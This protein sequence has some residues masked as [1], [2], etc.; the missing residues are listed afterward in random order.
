MR[1]FNLSPF[2]YIRRLSDKNEIE[3][4][5]KDPNYIVTVLGGL[6]LN[7]RDYEYK[8]SQV[9]L[10]DKRNEHKHLQF[11]YANNPV[12]LIEEELERRGLLKI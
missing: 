4:Y 6:Y 7:D 11:Y 1:S 10:G 9:F 8:T 5:K 2:N 3:H 12:R